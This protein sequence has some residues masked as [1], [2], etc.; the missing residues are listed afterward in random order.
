MYSTSSENTRVLWAAHGYNI[1]FSDEI[2]HWEYCNAVD[3][4]AFPFPCTSA[5]VGDPSL[6]GDDDL[7]APASVSLLV[8]VSGCTDS[9]EDFDGLSY[10]KVWPGITGNGPATT[11]GPVIFSSPTFNGGQQYS[12]LAFET[13]LPR[14]EATGLSPNNNCERFSQNG[15]GCV[16]PPNGAQFYPIFVARTTGQGCLWFEGG[17]DFPGLT[18]TFG[19]TSTS[20]FGPL[21]RL[22]YP[23]PTGNLPRFNDFRNVVPNT[24]PAS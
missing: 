16:N 10:Q 7:C 15:T 8:Q 13:D 6:D 21:L 3:F 4:S 19:G 23:A 2:G 14:I 11:P 18:Q 12:R 9:D 20:E 5:G 22:D 1:A 24:C 17:P